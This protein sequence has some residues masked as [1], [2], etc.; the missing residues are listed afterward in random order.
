MDRTNTAVAEDPGV[1]RVT[2][3]KW[4]NRVAALCPPGLL[5]EPRPGWPRLV[6]KEMATQEKGETPGPPVVNGEWL[7]ISMTLTI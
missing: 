2:V 3:T 6:K 1:N 4:R 7:A 5:D